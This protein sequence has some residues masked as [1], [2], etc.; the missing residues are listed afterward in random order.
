VGQPL[1]F[2]HPGVCFWNRTRARVLVRQDDYRCPPPDRPFT[3]PRFPP[4]G[5]LRSWALTATVSRADVR[6]P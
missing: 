4:P 5:F 1:A 6:L 2:F 3:K